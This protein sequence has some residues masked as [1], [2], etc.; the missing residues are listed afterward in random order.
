MIPVLTAAQAASWDDA[1]RT[2][3]GIPSLVLMESAGRA[4]AQVVGDEFGGA[5]RQGA[6]LAAG[7]GNNGGDGWVAARA[8][9]ALGIRVLAV[10]A[11]AKR[12]PD[13]DANRRLALASGVEPIA[14]D[15]QWPAVGVVLDALLGTGAA[16]APRGDIAGLAGRIGAFGA[17]VVAVDGPTGLDLTTGHS[18][19]PIR[20][21]LTITFGGMRRGHLLAREICGRIVVV[22]IGF[23]PGDPGWPLL[24]DDRWARATLP[25]FRAD[26]HKG[27]RGKVLVVGGEEGLAGAAIHATQATLVAGAGQVK[28][29]AADSTIR[30]ANDTTPDALTVRST[31]GFQDE[32]GLNDAVAWADVIVI[33]PGL[34]RSRERMNLVRSL[35]ATARPAVID[36]D[37]LYA[38]PEGWQAKAGPRVLTPHAGEFAAAFPKL[39]RLLGDDRF[40]AAERA[41]A[42][43]GATVLLKGVPTVV[44]PSHGPSVVVAAGTPALATGGSGDVLA[45]LIG[46]FLARGLAPHH[47]AALGAQAMGRAAESAAALN[48]ARAVRPAEVLAAVP[49]LW[50]RWAEEPR[51]RPP[52]LCEL[53]PPL[54]T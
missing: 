41:A 31:L 10:E 34:G 27:D 3:H 4:V 48:S 30:A 14:A 26:M 43:S 1:A 54:L 38:G 21:R 37:A 7:P 6:L 13:C 24:V 53:D 17:P 23:P 28:L 12:S 44:A 29:A 18:H 11:G 25:A 51:P 22:D 32:Q 47:A 35:L 39:K 9:K 46:A 52:V 50:K 36:A 5:L 2:K 20:A 15:A 40:A 45:G 19:D 8:L 16:G 33:G 42:E 49:S